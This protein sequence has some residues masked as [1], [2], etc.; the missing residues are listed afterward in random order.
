M[1]ILFISHKYPP[2][3][4]GMEKQCFELITHAAHNHKV[5]KLVHIAKEESKLSFFLKLKSNVKQILKQNPEI[6]IIHLNDGLMGLFLFWLKKYTSIPVVVTFHG[7]DLV[8]PNKWYQRLIGNKYTQYDAAICVSSATAMESVKRKF[9][10][11]NVFVVP[12]GVDHEIADFKSNKEKFIP[13]FEKKYQTRIANKRII[14]ML[15]RPVQRKGFSWFLKEVLPSLKEDVMV[16]MVGPLSGNNKTPLWKSLLPK[17]IA[18]QIELA[19]GGLSDEAAINKALQNPKIKNR[20]I[21]TGKL[22][23]NEVLEILSMASLFAM[24]N[25]K[26]A[27]DAEGFGLVALE[28]SL[29]N[30]VVLASHLEGI[31]EAIQHGKNGF[32]LPTADV[33]KWIDKIYELLESSNQLSQTEQEFKAFTLQNYGWE[34]MTREYVE[35]FEQVINRKASLKSQA[36]GLGEESRNLRVEY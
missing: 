21:Q 4:G 31:P 8:F 36:L 13:E 15:G 1:E 20:V 10:A 32:L 19:Q 16:V 5:H 14:A 3:I 30:T 28:A 23:F 17:S 9:R 22:P 35:V 7:L 11:K 25:V 33:N 12:N 34:K 18:K 27:G 24:P 6:D 29:R 26:R 2:A